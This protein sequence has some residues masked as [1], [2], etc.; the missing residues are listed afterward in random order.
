MNVRADGLYKEARVLQEPTKYHQ[1]PTSKAIF[2]LNDDP[3]HNDYSHQVMKAY[4]SIYTR[5]FL[6]I[7]YQWSSATIESIWWNCNAI[8]IKKLNENDRIRIQ[9]FK[10]NRLPTKHRD[11]MYYKYRSSSCSC[12]GHTIET[13]EPYTSVS[14]GF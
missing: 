7:K 5:Q 10:H 11:H 14:C 12:C 4:H 8:A 2:Y 3:V 1:F 9:K 6:C 13:E